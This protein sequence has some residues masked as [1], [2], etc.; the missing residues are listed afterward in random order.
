MKWPF[1]RAPTLIRVWDARPM[2][3]LSAPLEPEQQTLQQYLN[4]LNLVGR[5]VE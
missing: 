2:V 5:R 4:Y 3:E 1:C